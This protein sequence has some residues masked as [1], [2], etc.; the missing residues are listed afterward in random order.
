MNFKEETFSIIADF[1]NNV[2]SI[3]WQEVWDDSEKFEMVLDSLDTFTNC[4]AL[5]PDIDHAKRAAIVAKLAIGRAQLTDCYGDED[6]FNYFQAATHAL[7]DALKE[8]VTCSHWMTDA[9]KKFD[10]YLALEEEITEDSEIS[11]EQIDYLRPV[12]TLLSLINIVTINQEMECDS[13]GDDEEFCF[14]EE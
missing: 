1:R 3:D 9:Q 10:E 6:R 5:L 8:A 13:D 14:G 4:I 11:S 7:E 2:A 12:M